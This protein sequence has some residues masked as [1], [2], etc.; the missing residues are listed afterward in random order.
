MFGELIGEHRFKKVTILIS[1]VH[2]GRWPF[3][4]DLRIEKAEPPPLTSEKEIELQVRRSLICGHV[5]NCI[6]RYEPLINI[7]VGVD[8]LVISK[9]DF[10]FKEHLSRSAWW[11]IP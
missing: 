1:H 3:L 10:L 9:Y 8:K 2:D 7:L 11:L 4:N 5:L 6:S